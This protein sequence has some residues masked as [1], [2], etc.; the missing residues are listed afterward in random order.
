M[1]INNARS[2]LF[3]KSPEILNISETLL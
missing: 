2:A 3:F 1:L